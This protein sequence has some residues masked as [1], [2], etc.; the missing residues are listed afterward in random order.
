[1]NLAPVYFTQAP[2]RQTSVATETDQAAFGN[3]QE[4]DMMP[5]QSLNA[6]AKFRGTQTGV[7]KSRQPFCGA[8]PFVTSRKEFRNPSF[9]MIPVSTR[10]PQIHTEFT[11]KTEERG[12]LYLQQ[13][14]VMNEGH[15]RPSRG[16]VTLDPRYGTQTKGASAAYMVLE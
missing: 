1:M 16:D 5:T 14:P 6:E 4:S 15:L 12:P 13:W 2:D 9:R 10:S 8:L 7:K 3:W 11:Q